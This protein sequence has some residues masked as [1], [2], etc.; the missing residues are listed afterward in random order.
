MSSGN[1][2]TSDSF[3]LADDTGQASWFVNTLTETKVGNGRRATRIAAG[4]A[5]A[6]PPQPPAIGRNC[7]GAQPYTNRDRACPPMRYVKY[8]AVI[9]RR[10]S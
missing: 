5:P 2:V 3:V 10:W 7:H 9:W 6:V 4:Q 8:A 1:Q